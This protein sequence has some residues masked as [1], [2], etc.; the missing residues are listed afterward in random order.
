MYT[1]QYRWV[2]DSFYGWRLVAVQVY[3]PVIPQM[4]VPQVVR[5]QVV[6]PP[7]WGY[8]IR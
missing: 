6:P 2:F 5:P 7:Q 1:T 4:I 8:E 3:V